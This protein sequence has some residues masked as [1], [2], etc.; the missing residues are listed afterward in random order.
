MRLTRRI[1]GPLGGR[2]AAASTA[3]SAGPVAVPPAVLGAAVPADP[4]AGPGAAAGPVAVDPCA[5]ARAAVVDA[6]A[7]AERMAALSR[8]AQER[9]RDA[10]LAYDEHAGRRERAAAAGDPRAVRD[11]KDEA[12]AVFRRARLAARDQGAVEAAARAWLREIERINA[13]T[14]EAVRVVAREDAAEAALY[15]AVDRLGI[16]ADGARIAAESAAEACR[17]ARI[18]LASCEEGERLGREHA[19]VP[20]AAAG[21]LAP[22]SVV[23]RATIA[24]PGGVDAAESE[25]APAPAAGGPAAPAP[26]AA[27]FAVPRPAAPAAPPGGP[28][29]ATANDRE[30]APPAAGATDEAEVEPVVLPLLAGDRAVLRRLAATLAGGDAA[31]DARWQAQLAAFVEAVRA[32][33][34]DGAALVFPEAHAFWG[35]Y[36]QVQCREIAAALAALGF[37]FDGLDG[38]A[39]GRVPGQRELSLAIGYAGLDPMRVRIWPTEAELPHL[40]ADVVVD[41]G[42]FVAEAAGELSLGEMIDLLGRRAE[43]LGELWNTWGR[44]RPLLLSPA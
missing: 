10:R 21:A 30:G 27:S 24:P 39:D 18:S 17:T 34:V 33:A 31:A 20:A 7:L 22:A 5:P 3:T 43:D 6:C 40:F 16:E 11:A 25:A 23:A 35:P 32:R 19:P 26:A 13:Q 38:F 8:A 14:R 4:S 37:R 36:T 2:R 41:A 15:R 28:A 1:V 44:V 9:L 12:Q 42:R 29:T